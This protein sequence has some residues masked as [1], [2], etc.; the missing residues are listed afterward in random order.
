MSTHPSP[1]FH[2]ISN[3]AGQDLCPVLLEGPAENDV[4]D[5]EEKKL[6]MELVGKVD[7]LKQ[8]EDGAGGGEEGV[9]G[10]GCERGDGE[11]EPACQECET[12]T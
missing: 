9:Q 8:V 10:E 6:K 12:S 3:E 1:A 4:G 7:K 11:D 2:L 5:K